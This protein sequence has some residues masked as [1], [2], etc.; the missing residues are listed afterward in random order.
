MR[1]APL[2]LLA[3][4]EAAP[5]SLPKT[6]PA[7]VLTAA[8]VEQPRVLDRPEETAA[9]TARKTFRNV[10][11]LGGVSSERFLAAMQ[12]MGRNV[13]LRGLDCHVQQDYS[14]DEKRRR[15]AGQPA[16]TADAAHDRTCHRGEVRPARAPADLA[17]G[18]R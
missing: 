6:D 17:A 3:A 5:S 14:S 1:T 9:Q 2:L 13:G 4:C 7:T 10:H 11:A 15:Q 18:Q 8:G 12:S 16:R